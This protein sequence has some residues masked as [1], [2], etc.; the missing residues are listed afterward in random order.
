MQKGSGYEFMQRYNMGDPI[1]VS[2]DVVIIG[3]GFTAVD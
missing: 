1:P 3:G 2:G